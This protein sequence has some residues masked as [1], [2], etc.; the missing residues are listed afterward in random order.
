VPRSGCSHLMVA[1]VGMIS[2]KWMVALSTLPGGE[3]ATTY[4]LISACALRPPAR[5]RK[6]SRHIAPPHRPVTGSEGG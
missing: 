1:P 6:G 3:L 2:S 5:S 4:S